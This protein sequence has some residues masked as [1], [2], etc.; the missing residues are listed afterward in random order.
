M[1]KNLQDLFFVVF[2][3]SVLE[4]LKIEKIVQLKIVNDNNDFCYNKIFVY[5]KNGTVHK[6]RIDSRIENVANCTTI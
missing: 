6:N 1:E 5:Q 3:R 4:N 2:L